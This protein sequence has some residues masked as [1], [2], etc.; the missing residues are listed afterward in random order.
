MFQQVGKACRRHV[1][2]LDTGK[3]YL[4]ESASAKTLP[5]FTR[6]GF[7]LCL[8]TFS[9]P[10]LPTTAD[11]SSS[12]TLLQVFLFSPRGWVVR[13]TQTTKEQERSQLINVMWMSQKD[14]KEN[15]IKYHRNVARLIVGGVE[16]AKS[17]TFLSL[18]RLRS[19]NYK[20]WQV[21]F[22]AYVSLCP[23][24]NQKTRRD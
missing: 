6:C 1:A 23:L 21:I 12:P 5:F 18:G 13:R 24:S 3:N 11:F 15:W 2:Q 8:W 20:Y 16:M 22:I 4:N 19:S 10:H 14:L 9:I 7:F 17:I